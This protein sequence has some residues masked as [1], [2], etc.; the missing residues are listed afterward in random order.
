MLFLHGTSLFLSNILQAIPVKPRPLRSVWNQFQHPNDSL[1]WIMLLFSYM[2]CFLWNINVKPRR[3]STV[4][5]SLVLSDS[6]RCFENFWALGRFFDLFVDKHKRA[7]L[8]VEKCLVTSWPCPLILGI[9]RTD[10]NRWIFSALY[11]PLFIQ[12]MKHLL[13]ALSKTHKF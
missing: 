4:S 6:V 8:L 5:S 9:F 13:T 1:Q 3:A 7:F 11:S 12:F 10:R 2:K